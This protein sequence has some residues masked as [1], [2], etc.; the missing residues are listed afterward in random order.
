[1]FWFKIDLNPGSFIKCKELG[2][3]RKFAR[4]QALE[5]G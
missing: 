5:L 2:Q 3:I 4:E 1:M